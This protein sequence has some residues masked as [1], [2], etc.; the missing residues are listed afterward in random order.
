MAQWRLLRRIFKFVG[1]V[2]FQVAV[3][4]LVFIG[5]IA[6]EVF[7]V[8]LLKPAIDVV[9]QLRAGAGT[10]ESLLDWFLAVEGPG[11]ALRHAIL[12]LAVAKLVLSILSWARSVCGSWQGMS[13]VFYMRAAVYDQ[14]QRVGFAFHDHYSTGQLINRALSDLGAVRTFI[15][16]SLHSSIDILFSLIGYFAML[17]YDGSWQIALAALI[18]VPFWFWAIRRYAILSRPIYER[19]MLASDEMV[20]LLTENV[21]GVHVVRAFATEAH[22]Q[23]KFKTAC[24]TLTTRLL[25][26][27]RLRV[28]MMPIIR[29]I[30][31]AANIGLFSLG[32]IMVQKGQLEL[33]AL[34]A[35]GVAMN[36]ILS[37]IQQ[38]NAISDAYQRAVVSSGRLFEI[39]DTPNTT[40]EPPD[41]ESL[42]P[43]GGAVRLT[44]VSFGYKPA[45]R[46][47]H[48]ISFSVPAGAVV[49]LVG[50]T[51][52]GKTTLAG[53]LA[54][55]YDPQEGTVEIDGQ[56]VRDVTLRSVRD[57]VGFAFQETYLFSDTIARNIAYADLHAP[58]DKIIAAAR[59]ARAG[60][61]IERLP[62]QYETVIGEYGATLSGGQRQRLSIARAIL[63]NPRILVLD[64]ALAAVDPETEALIRAS[65][66]HVMAGRTV[67]II[68]SRIATAR[69]ANF[70][71]VVENGRLT[72]FGTHEELMKQPGYYRDVAFAQFAGA[73]SGHEAS[74]MDRMGQLGKASARLLH[75]REALHGSGGAGS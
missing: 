73:Y 14:L 50:P 13:M 17:L 54:R 63:H 67:F 4:S 51:G 21:A 33:G 61:F 45:Q 15:N 40:P 5:Y 47:L 68:T 52:A 69:R 70:I 32:A 44:H 42:R 12:A 8:R 55:F 46:V 64:D 9:S 48:G 41:A 38:I 3:T 60:G 24:Q 65:L 26:G 36:V 28:Q 20:R 37:R 10:G 1:P 35:F 18:P 29:G 31:A 30:A 59:C 58:M 34:V 11:A 43:G 23:A 6:A 74:H 19:Q 7:A 72:H 53:L 62:K 27:V 56:D 25:E 39:L 2:K 22:E 49:A 66:E 57:S 16:V 71:M 75:D